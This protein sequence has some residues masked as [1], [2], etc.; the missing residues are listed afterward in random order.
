MAE[1]QGAVGL[2]QA[3]SLIAGLIEG[4]VRDAVIS[5][6]S[7]S[8]PLALACL[9]H[10]KV[11]CRILIDERSA[12]FFALGVARATGRPVVVVATSGSAPANWYPALIE[13]HE[14]HVPLVFVS[15]D[16]PPELQDCGANQTTDQVAM[17]G[18]RVRA[19]LSLAPAS[20]QRQDLAYANSVGVR[21]ADFALWPHPGPVHVNAAFREPLVPT[22]LHHPPG[23]SSPDYRSA[24]VARPES[25]PDR[26]A[27]GEIGRVLAS[28]RGVIVCG[29]CAQAEIDPAGLV[30]LAEKCDA[31]ILSDP[32]SGLRHGPWPKR[33][34]IS[35]YD[36]LLRETAPGIPD[37]L[38][39][40]GGTPVS[41]SLQQWMSRPDMPHAMIIAKHPPWS[42]PSLRAGLVVH[43]E[44]CL[45]ADMLCDMSSSVSRGDWLARWRRADDAIAAQLSVSKR[46]PAEATLMRAL[47]D[48]VPQHASVFLGNSM[49]IRDADSFLTVR[50]SHLAV[51][52]NRGV[53]GIDGNVST[54]AG[55]A[56]ATEGPTIA[57]V[58]DVAL[59]HDLNALSL[60]ARHS[61][62]V[63]VVNNGGGAIFGY[64]PQRQLPEFDRAWLTPP[65]LD[66]A[67]AAELFGLACYRVDEGADPA[68]GLQAALSRRGGAV[69]DLVVN[70]E[71]SLAAHR[72][73][74]Q[75]SAGD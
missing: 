70:R 75:L 9:R 8:T 22:G 53:S 71:R 1:D 54:A 66:F 46:V 26:W 14:D 48:V 17:F 33:A 24:R 20:G 44:P 16:R 10:E 29:P 4:G 73:W 15:A 2:R 23:A 34:V 6:G 39:Q 12:A 62:T 59:F 64:L 35:C 52:G 5:P 63:V 31:P 50:D 65:E 28:G 42:D 38:L 25:T 72:D 11:S 27:I 51:F 68:P 69:V 49:V 57:V 21:A 56:S 13:A 37:W 67:R 55:I 58:G 36:A 43:A 74:W 41:K 30:R 45:A 47:I 40:F 61:L 18:R 32:L 19:H 60:A 7:R 3:R